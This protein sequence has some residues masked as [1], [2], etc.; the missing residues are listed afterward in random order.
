MSEFE[1]QA[2]E[3]EAA[4]LGLIPVG[5]PRDAQ[6]LVGQELVVVSPESSVGDVGSLVRVTGLNDDPL[7]AGEGAY[8]APLLIINGVPNGGYFS[9]RF[10]YPV[11]IEWRLVE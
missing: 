7:P 11:R 2:A 3:A 5:M 1:R 10:A 8:D 6:G 9:W 4:R